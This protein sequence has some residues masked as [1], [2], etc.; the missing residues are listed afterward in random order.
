VHP[1]NFPRDTK[2]NVILVAR[3]L[4]SSIAQKFLGSSRVTES[5]TLLHVKS[6][7]VVRKEFINPYLEKEVQNKTTVL[8]PT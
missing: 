6:C 8:M 7:A 5:R 4:L 1:L 2:A 3:L